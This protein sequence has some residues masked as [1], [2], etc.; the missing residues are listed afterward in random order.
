MTEGVKMGDKQLWL[1][2]KQIPNPGKYPA[3]RRE[4]M[5][6]TASGLGTFGVS[7]GL[8]LVL[9]SICIYSPPLLHSMCSAWRYYMHADLQK[10]HK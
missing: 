3:R 5:L 6:F 7:F 2:G 1:R 10:K 4:R 9:W 8:D